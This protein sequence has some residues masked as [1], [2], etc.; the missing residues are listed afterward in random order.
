[1]AH[2]A[3]SSK[4]SVKAHCV[5]SGSPSYLCKVQKTHCI[6]LEWGCLKVCNSQCTCQM[7][8][9]MCLQMLREMGSKQKTIPVQGSSLIQGQNV[10]DTPFQFVFVCLVYV[11]VCA[12]T[13]VSGFTDVI[14]KRGFPSC[15]GSRRISV[16]GHPDI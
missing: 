10:E 3:G 11:C 12:H 8:T 5:R 16:F 7:S 1:M 14:R 15:P 2:T 4:R 6:Q 9:V 13:C